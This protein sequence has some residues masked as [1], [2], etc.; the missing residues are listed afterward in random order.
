MIKWFWRALFISIIVGIVLCV[1]Y[2]QYNIA[3]VTATFSA[4]IV[5]LFKD[6][7]LN[8]ILP[9]IL[10]IHTSTDEDYLNELPNELEN[11]KELECWLSVSVENKGT[12]VAKNVCVYFRGINS[13][14]IEKIKGY[15]HLQLRRSHLEPK[16]NWKI[17]PI[18]IPPKMKFHYGFCYVK[19]NEPEKF[20]FNFSRI[21]HSFTEVLCPSNDYSYFEFEIIA[22]AENSR[23]FVERYKIEYNGNYRNG[24]TVMKL[25][26][27]K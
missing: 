19:K 16:P 3:L 23:K 25:K 14:R 7:I 20:Y 10:I 4:V 1:I 11:L 17:R 18:N 21:P 12:R 13:N 27:D 9:P 26:K 22:I 15:V 8:I 2:N 6:E 24:I 5:A